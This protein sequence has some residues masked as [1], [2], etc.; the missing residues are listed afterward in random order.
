VVHA[1]VYLAAIPFIRTIVFVLGY[2]CII[3]LFVELMK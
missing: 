1:V 3:G 2:V